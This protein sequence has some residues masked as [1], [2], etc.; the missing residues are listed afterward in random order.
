MP[1][2]SRAS[3]QFNLVTA[4]L[5]NTDTLKSGVVGVA[6]AVEVDVRGIVIRTP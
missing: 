1:L 4:E 3:L 5:S 2:Y 6:E